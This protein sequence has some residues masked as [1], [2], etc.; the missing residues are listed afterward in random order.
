MKK[1]LV[2]GGARAQ[3]ELIRTAKNMGISTLVVGTPGDYP[4]Y[5]LADEYVPVD[6]FNKEDVLSIAKKHDINGISIV[7]SDF[8]LSTVGYVCDKMNLCGLSEYSANASSNKLKMKEVF[9]GAGVRTAKYRKIY[10]D[11]DVIKASKELAFPLIVKAVDLQGSRGIYI[12]N[13]ID[14]LLFYYKESI[15]ESR[16]DYCIVEEFIVGEEF[17]AQAYV[18][19]GDILFVLPH[20]DITIK[21]NSTQVPC[22]HYTPYKEE[23]F[24]LN[25]KI[26]DVCRKAIKALSLDNCAVNIDLIL[27][28]GEPYIIEV[29]G[30][31]GANC[32]PELV[33][34]KY[35]INY[36]QMVI[37]GAVGEDPVSYFKTGTISSKAIMTKMI[38]SESDALVDEVL[39]CPPDI[40]LFVK[41]GGAIR[42]FTNSRDYIGQTICIDDNIRNCKKKISEWESQIIFKYKDN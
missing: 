31:A 23:D 21:T 22:Y 40:N 5:K 13:N 2:L 19:N 11:E 27:K 36:Y 17:G 38:Y 16:L 20:G 14:E 33:S 7:C 41:P 34:A 30:R 6:I 26:D 24:E 4:G 8:G 10:K 15:N 35:G 39:C 12:C 1:L 32:L 3:L 28:E 37:L 18:H 25:K 9:E 42:K 29:A